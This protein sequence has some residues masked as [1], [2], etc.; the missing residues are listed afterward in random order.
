[1]PFG[2]FSATACFARNPD[3]ARSGQDALRHYLEFGIK[4]GRLTGAAL[5]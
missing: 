3:V 5:G 4:E 2:E 1:M